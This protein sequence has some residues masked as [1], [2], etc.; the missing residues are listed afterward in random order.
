[1]IASVGVKRETN[2][3]MEI[4]NEPYFHGEDSLGR[5]YISRCQQPREDGLSTQQPLILFTNRVKQKCVQKYATY[6]VLSCVIL[7]SRLSKSTPFDIVD[8]F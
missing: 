3:R 1:M 7:R 5:T 2:H 4:D 6:F 8:G